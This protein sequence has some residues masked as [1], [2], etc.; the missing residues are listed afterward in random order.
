MIRTFRKPRDDQLT[1]N[2]LNKLLQRYNING[3]EVNILEYSK[4]FVI[5]N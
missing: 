4:M 5:G 3:R 1:S 2:L